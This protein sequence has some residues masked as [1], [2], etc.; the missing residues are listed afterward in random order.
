MRQVSINMLAV[1]ISVAVFVA[2]TISTAATW[3]LVR[4]LSIRRLRATRP[5]SQDIDRPNQQ[6]PARDLWAPQ[7]QVFQE[8]EKQLLTDASI[9]YLLKRIKDLKFYTNRLASQV[10]RCAWKSTTYHPTRV[11]EFLR[12]QCYPTEE[13]TPILKY[14]KHIYGSDTPRTRILSLEGL[15]YRLLITNIELR[16][17]PIWTLLC[18]EYIA[19]AHVLDQ[20]SLDSFKTW[21]W[22]K[23]RVYLVN[24]LWPTYT[25]CDTLLADL[26]EAPPSKD[27]IEKLKSFIVDLLRDQVELDDVSRETLHRCCHLASLIGLAIHKDLR[28]WCWSYNH[29]GVM[30][31]PF[32]LQR[33]SKND[34]PDD[35]RSVQE[36]CWA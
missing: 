34:R 7:P 15:I 5:I 24:M 36:C 14:L 1:W 26:G 35:I 17:S 19:L 25:R 12:Q 30:E 33:I 3:W 11:E 27:A 31:G 9:T 6:P 18:P 21:G 28:R 32:P 20:T 13:H 4:F 16:G 10:H 8:A 2:V 22:E 29:V 23:T